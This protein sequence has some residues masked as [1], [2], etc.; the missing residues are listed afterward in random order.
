MDELTMV[1]HMLH[2]KFNRMRYTH[3]AQHATDNSMFLEKL[4]WKQHLLRQCLNE[5]NDR[6]ASR[7]VTQLSEKDVFFLSTLSAKNES[8]NMFLQSQ[9]TSTGQNSERGSSK[10][11]QTQS[12]SS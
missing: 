8:S 1:E 2:E 12:D 3:K 6:L 10:E 7:S 5:E 11:C 4:L 9:S